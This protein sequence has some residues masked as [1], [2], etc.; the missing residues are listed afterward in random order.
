[1]NSILKEFHGQ[2]DYGSTEVME[3]HFNPA[4]RD[5][6]IMKPR[7]RVKAKAKPTRGGARKGAGRPARFEGVELRAV[8]TL[9]KHHGLTD[10]RAILAAD[11]RSK[12]SKLRDLTVFPKPV[13]VSMP[14]LGTIA[15]EAG[16]ELHRGRKAAA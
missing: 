11:G 8:V 4:D 15:S 7:R 12:L 1:M 5:T 16:I 2:G 14:T 9:I 10:S 13:S 6:P 3:P